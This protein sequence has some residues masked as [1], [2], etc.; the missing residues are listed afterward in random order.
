MKK[1]LFSGLIILTI[2]AVLAGNASAQSAIMR[3]TIPFDFY[4]GKTAFPSGEYQV[5]RVSSV[6]LRI[7]G[8][9]GQSTFVIPM[10]YQSLAP[11]KSGALIFHRYGEQYFLARTV[12][13][14]RWDGQAFAPSSL[15]TE[16]ARNYHTPSTLAL[17]AK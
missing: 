7:S 4:V 10:P 12:W 15:E 13:M 1:H 2:F 9:G 14:G 5:Q 3:A 11:A 16:L 6:V 17:V 8:N